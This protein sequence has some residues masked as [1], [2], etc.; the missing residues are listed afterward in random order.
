[1]AALEESIAAV[2]GKGDGKAKEA[3]GESQEDAK[4]RA[5]ES[6]RRKN[7]KS[8]AKVLEVA[9]WALTARSRSRDVS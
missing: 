8:K 2:K 6:R 5:E 1:M 3:G 4:R 7:R 9:P